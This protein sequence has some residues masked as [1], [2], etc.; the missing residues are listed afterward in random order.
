MGRDDRQRQRYIVRPGQADQPVERRGRLDR[1]VV[2]QPEARRAAGLAPARQFRRAACQAI[3]PL[4][5]RS[6]EHRAKPRRGDFER[7]LLEDEAARRRGHRTAPFRVAQQRANRRR[8]GRHIAL[9]RQNARLP[10]AHH[11][12]H[13]CNVLRDD[14]QAGCLCLE[15]GKPIGLAETGPDQEIA[16]RED[17]PG[18]SCAAALASQTTRSGPRPAKAA[19][20]LLAAGAVADHDSRHGMSRRGASASAS[21]R[22][23]SI[24]SPGRII[25]TVSRVGG[26]VSLAA[27]DEGR[28]VDEGRQM[29]EPLGR[30][31]LRQAVEVAAGEADVQRRLPRLPRTTLSWRR[32]MRQRCGGTRRMPRP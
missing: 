21:M 29:D 8:V 11:L 18:S 14:R 26:T 15:I 25:A 4:M 31:Q 30:H 1:I 2:A 16:F 24:L 28:R 6:F 23:L 27:S 13:A 12:R 9:R 5:P 17:V 20:H 7:A 19:T 22:K 3:S 32:P 10:V